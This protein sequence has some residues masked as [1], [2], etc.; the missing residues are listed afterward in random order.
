MEKVILETHERFVPVSNPFG[1]KNN[2]YTIDNVF[3][4]ERGKIYGVVCEHGGGGESISLLLSN[5]VPREEEKIYFDNQEVDPFTVGQAG[6][7][8]GKSLYSG[9]LIKREITLRMA[10]KYAV[11]R[12]HKYKSIE[13]MAEDFVLEPGIWDYGLS[14]SCHWVKWRAS[15]AI[16]YASNKIIYCFP[17]MNTLHFYDCLINSSV[18]RFFKRFKEEGLIVILP[19]SRTENVEG[20]VDEIIQIHCPRFERVVTNNEYFREHF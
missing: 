5:Q 14:R 20:V 18:F 4:F 10:M 12:Y 9:T 16:G 13:E 15:L 8:M 11:N 1:E 17:R 7:Y 19:T 2:D 6:W 3:V